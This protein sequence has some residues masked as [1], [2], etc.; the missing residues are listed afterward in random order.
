MVLGVL[1][2]GLY[3]SQNLLQ[4]IPLGF[5]TELKFTPCLGNIDS[6]ENQYHW[7]KEA[8]SSNI[9]IF[10]GV[11]LR[12]SWSPCTFLQFDHWHLDLIMYSVYMPG[13]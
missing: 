3:F 2:L 12:I 8:D 13:N 1:R 10:K 5:S 9:L 4:P 7:T 11:I 6:Y